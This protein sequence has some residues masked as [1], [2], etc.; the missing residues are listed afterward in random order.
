[1]P[2]LNKTGLPRLAAISIRTVRLLT[3]SIDLATGSRET[4]AGRSG[5][6]SQTKARSV[7]CR[8]RAAGPEALR[9]ERELS[10]QC[11]ILEGLIHEDR[12]YVTSSIARR[13]FRA[14]TSFRVAG[15]RATGRGRRP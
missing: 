14:G 11:A 15:F 6:P 5:I 10:D 12:L 3:I 2:L 13:V 4:G 7:C 1:M 8:H 9:L